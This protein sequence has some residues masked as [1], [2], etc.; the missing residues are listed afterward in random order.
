MHDQHFPEKNSTCF[1]GGTLALHPMFTLFARRFHWKHT[2]F[3][4]IGER[5]FVG[6]CNMD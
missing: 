6:I 4:S 2:Q 3:Q 5:Q 1:F